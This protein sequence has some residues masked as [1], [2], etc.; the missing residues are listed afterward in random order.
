[1]ADYVVPRH[2]AVMERLRRRIELFRRHHS[3]CEG[4]YDSTAL[5]RL[6]MERQHT[7]ALHQRC[8]QSKAKRSSKHRQAPPAAP[9]QNAPG[10]HGAGGADGSDGAPGEQSRNSTLIALQDTVKRKLENTGS[11]GG[12]VNGFGEAYPNS[13]RSCLEE[14]RGGVAAGVP[15]PSPHE[16]KLGVIGEVSHSN[17]NCPL[18]AEQKGS[19][20]HPM[21]Q[22]QDTELRV[23]EMK[24]E[25]VDDFLPCVLPAGST[26]GNGN[27]LPDLTLNEQE[28]R[29]LM[30]EFNYEDIEDIF[31]E[32][33]DERRDTLPQTPA[34]SDQVNI[35]AEFS[36]ASVAFDQEPRIA[37]PQ[38]HLTS[39]GP[40]LHASSP[41]TS[42]APSPALSA[43]QAP[44]QL[45]Q[46]LQLPGPPPKDLSPA[47]QLQQL[48]A[49]E[50]QRAQLIQTQQQT[51]KFTAPNHQSNHQS[52]HQGAWT[53]PTASQS[54]LASTCGLEK[55]TNPGLYQQ[56]FSNSKQLMSNLLNKSSPK[57]SAGSYPQGGGHSVL[58]QSPMLDYASTRPLSHFQTNPGPR[59]PTATPLNTSTPPTQNKAVLL[60]LLRQQAKQKAGIPF[61]SPLP[62]GQEQG[63]YQSA[64]HIPDPT[65]AMANQPPGNSL[66]G[67]HGNASYMGGPSV[68]LDQQ[69]TFHLGQRQHLLAQQEKQ[70]QMQRHLNRPPPQYQDQQ[71][72]QNSQ[73]PFQ[74]QDVSQFPG[75]SQQ[76]S[77]V[78]T[79]GGPNPGGQRMFAQTQSMMG[80]GVGQSGGP[81]PVAPSATGLA[82]MG[83][84]SCGGGGL[85]NVQQA[86]YSNMH[87][88]AGQTGVVN[89]TPMQRQPPGTMA[90]SFRQ[91]LLA[92]Q[93]VKGQSNSALLKQQ[94][95]LARMPNSMPNTMA[96]GMVNTMPNTI[97]TSV[98]NAMA[99]SLPTS[100]PNQ[101]S[102]AM[103]S[104]MPSAMT[105]AMPNSMSGPLPNPMSSPMPTSMPSSMSTQSQPWQPHPTMQQTLGQQGPAGNGGMQAFSSSP[106]HMQPR[107]PKLP[108]SAPFSQA[109]LNNG[110]PH[111]T[112][113]NTQVMGNLPQP[114]NNMALGSQPLR[115]LAPP[116]RALA[117]APQKQQLLPGM[118]TPVPDM[119]AFGQAQ[120][121]QVGSHT[122]LQCNQSYSVNRTA[123]HELPF[124]YNDQPGSGLPSLPE[125][126]DLMDSLLKSHASQGWMDELDELLAGHQ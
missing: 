86:L 6:E 77:N 75:S 26:G 4:R 22:A 54:Q 83:L 113:S 106:Y 72:Q 118:N 51:V 71:N 34:P 122:N 80:M 119:A 81:T 82:D 125:E 89:S 35:K 79:L 28:W 42:T 98:P 85:D 9:D 36:P 48:A 73:N 8:L 43:P 91:N 62:L 55:Q 31:N 97:S 120:A 70:Q 114:R 76:L 65:T 74:Q 63:S 64:A 84:P 108:N 47:Q 57:A 93:H 53:Q 3:S 19:A 101:M 11:P 41:V 90:T 100:V 56:D 17:G 5:E 15:P 29:E 96:N 50:Q 95:H 103:P 124:G 116:H 33:F 2:S 115:P 88:H 87:P 92:Q 126:S 104:S 111:P 25:P 40:P 12:E 38:V 78:G 7:F 1:M 59:G 69:K 105:N 52:K 23:K 61:R 99:G 45:P 110:R 107:L 102:S 24:Q 60:S 18:G 30:A 94:Q 27:L 13:K 49:R 117:P 20:L 66:A 39:C 68:S 32:G 21:A 58:N 112:M 44:R 37:S 16:T 121:S 14:G 10:G 46:N 67:S 123:N 109:S